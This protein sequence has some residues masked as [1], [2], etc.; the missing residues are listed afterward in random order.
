MP[1]K[2]TIQTKLLKVI[3]ITC[4][5]AL[6]LTGIAYF[7]YEYYSY[8]EFARRQMVTVGEIIAANSS[9]SLSFLYRED[10][11][12]VLRSLNKQ[13]NIVAASLY[14]TSGRL[15][16]WYPDSLKREDLPD[17]VLS[18]GF[19]YSNDYL[20]GFQP[21]TQ[22]G[23]RKGTLYIRSDVKDVYS[24]FNLYGNITIIFIL[25]SFGIAYLLS[26]RLQ[27]HITAPILDLAG[28]ARII[29]TKKDYSIRARKTADDETG[30]L[31]DAFNSMLAEIESQNQRIL[32]LNHSLEEKVADRTVELSMANL[33]LRQQKELIETIV[34]SSVDLI[35]VFNKNLEYE[36]INK[37]GTIVYNMSKEEMVGR[38][39]LELFPALKGGVL[40]TNIKRALD[41]E[42]THVEGYKSPVS[43]RWFENFFIPLRNKDG[44]VDRVLVVGHDITNI[45]FT[46]LKLESLNAELEKSNKSLEQ[47][48]YVASHDLQEPLR[49]IQTF[50]ELSE[51][52]INN[53]EALQKY[54]HKING[55]ALRMSDLI[56]SVLNYS[57]LEKDADL[58]EPV[59]L[60]AVIESIKND[61]E[62]VID[63][64]SAEIKTTQLPVVH[65]IALQLQQLFQNLV[66][67]SL[68]FSE[69][70]PQ[71]FIK[72]R[73]VDGEA[74]S[75]LS[76]SPGDHLELQFSDNGIG[77]EQQ[78]ADKAFSIFQRL[79]T[80]PHYTG[81]GIGLALCKK[82]VENHD[83]K[84][85]VQSEPGKGT[86][87]YIYI[88]AQYVLSDKKEVNTATEAMKQKRIS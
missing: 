54:L 21:V 73:M 86:T 18:Q 35:A 51:S 57:R 6:V 33:T 71:I 9:S 80:Q 31:A 2:N 45:M 49:K 43:D 47:F 56:R 17:K 37:P 24:R 82:I 69:R 23:K 11:Q 64:K 5:S 34:D 12:E 81:T 85:T 50:A 16:A 59:D 75:H 76:L 30:Q 10:A 70:A 28:T 13:K 15:F 44:E 48:A 7:I 58:F 65:G 78:Y 42:F 20:E 53:P 8:R 84:I 25:L 66:T 63:E 46:N 72:S 26:R 62:L 1:T 22:E 68:K 32:A 55:S 77:F 83:G 60:N 87:F 74:V 61:L 79:H 38:N 41:G 67:N 29:S 4:G 19:F 40:E 36:M 27:K 3:M 88:P 39:V 52:N 14:D